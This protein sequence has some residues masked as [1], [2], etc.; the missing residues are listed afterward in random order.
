VHSHT[1]KALTKNFRCSPPGTPSARSQWCQQVNKYQS[2]IASF[3]DP[4]PLQAGSKACLETQRFCDLPR[5]QPTKRGPSNVRRLL[6]AIHQPATECLGCNP[7]PWS[8]NRVL[9]CVLPVCFAPTEYPCVYGGWRLSHGRLL[10]SSPGRQ[11]R[12]NSLDSQDD[13]ISVYVRNGIDS[14]ARRWRIFFAN[15]E[16]RAAVFVF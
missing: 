15:T 9:L 1:R 16:T 4:G 5:M 6:C 2:A 14:S 11:T 3:G 7:D 12:R 13:P 8:W 10:T